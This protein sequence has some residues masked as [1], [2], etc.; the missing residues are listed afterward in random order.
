MSDVVA[1]LVSRVVGEVMISKSDVAKK[2]G[3]VHDRVDDAFLETGTTLKHMGRLVSKV[4]GAIKTVRN[5]FIF[6]F[7]NFANYVVMFAED[8]LHTAVRL[9]EFGNQQRHLQFFLFCRCRVFALKPSANPFEG[10]SYFSSPAK[11]GEI[12]RQKIRERTGRYA[13]GDDESYS[14]LVLA[15]S[16]DIDQLGKDLIAK[17]VQLNGGVAAE[18]FFKKIFRGARKVFRQVGK[19]GLEIGKRIL[20]QKA[21]EIIRQKIRER[22]GR[23]ALG[24]DES[25]SGLVLA[26]SEDIDQLGKDLIVKGVQLN[27]GVVVQETIWDPDTKEFLKDCVAIF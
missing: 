10:F 7:V 16:E 19:A 18:Y 2:D 9:L 24:D 12:I 13:L 5:H 6:D 26:L 23:Y 20:G 14:G 3:S 11:A 25:Y 22:T 8:V 17:G 4:G 21:G 27:G 1:S 15:L